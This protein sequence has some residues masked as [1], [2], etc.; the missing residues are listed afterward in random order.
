MERAPCP[1][2]RLACILTVRGT[3]DV[4]E[5]SP[6]PDAATRRRFYG[7][8]TLAARADYRGRFHRRSN[9]ERQGRTG[10]CH[11]GLW[12]TGPAFAAKRSNPGF[13]RPSLVRNGCGGFMRYREVARKLAT[14]GCQELPRKG[15][16]HIANGSNQFPGKSRCCRIEEVAI[17]KS[18][19]FGPDGD[20]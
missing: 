8:V 19:R 12:R 20:Q 5:D 10:G 16:A 13:Q 14:L 3:T 9:G 15:A 4:L 6:G 18:V 11:R 2:S 17:S 1:F 7:H